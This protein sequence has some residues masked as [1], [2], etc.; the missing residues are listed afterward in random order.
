MMYS[1]MYLCWLYP[2]EL[3]TACNNIC[4]YVWLA[5][6]SFAFVIISDGGREESR[7]VILS[8]LLSSRRGPLFMLG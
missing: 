5:Y 1:S 8:S 2:K 3:I 6:P 7:C 4:V